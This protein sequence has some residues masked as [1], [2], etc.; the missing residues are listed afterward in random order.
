MRVDHKGV[1][2]VGINLVGRTQVARMA[3]QRQQELDVG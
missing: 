2:F 1:D 3:K